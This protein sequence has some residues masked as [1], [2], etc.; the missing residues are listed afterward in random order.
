M[1]KPERVEVGQWW[2]TRFGGQ[3]PDRVT[4]DAIA[5]LCAFQS[6]MSHWIDA[7][8]Y[9]GSGDHPEPSEWM[10]ET[11]AEHAYDIGRVRLPPTWGDYP[12]EKQTNWRYCVRRT[13]SGE[14]DILNEQLTDA[15]LS[16][17][18]I[19]RSLGKW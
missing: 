4:P 3:A 2:V 13:L 9:L 1:K 6:E 14:C 7:R 11:L 8:D 12:D 5:A 15:V 10:I 16:L 18:S 19:L 17:Y